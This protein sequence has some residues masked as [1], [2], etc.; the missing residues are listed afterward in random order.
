MRSFAPRYALRLATTCLAACLLPSL[1]TA[2]E[3]DDAP[4]TIKAGEAF[5]EEQDDRVEAF[6]L[7]AHGH[8][9]LQQGD[10]AGALRRFERAWR[11]DP[12]LV[13]IMERIVPIAF[14]LKHNDEATR[15][16]AIAAVQQEVPLPL[17]ERTAA[18]LAQQEQFEAACSLYEKLLNDPTPPGN[19]SVRVIHEFEIARL[20]FLLG[21][22][23]TAA[24]AFDSVRKALEQEGDDALL[25]E[26]RQQLLARPELTYTLMAESFLRDQRLDDAEAMFRAADQAKPRPG[27]LGYHLAQV[28]L[29]RGKKN[30]AEQELNKYFDA[31]L[32]SAGMAPYILLAKLIDGELPDAK[33]AADDDAVA[34]DPASPRLL[35][36]LQTLADHDPDNPLLGY[37]LADRLLRAG[38]LQR[39]ETLYKQLLDQGPSADG[40][41]G[42]VSIYSQQNKINPLLEQLGNLAFQTGSVEALDDVSQ[43]LIANEALWNKLNEAMQA[44]LAEEGPKLPKGSQM[45]M[46]LLAAEAKDAERAEQYM[47]AALAKPGIARGQFAINYAFQMFRLEEP[48]R[49]AAAFRRAIDDKLMPERAAEL[50]FYLSGA[51]T[52]DGQYDEALEAARQAA[53]LDP[54]SPRFAGRVGWVQYQAK[55]VE[56]A[57]DVYLDLMAKYDKDHTSPDTREVMRDARLILSTIA[58]EQ[59]RIGAAEEWLEQVLDEFPEDIGALNDLGYLWCDQN[60]H[61]KRSLAM[62]QKAVEA[63]P[64]NMAYRDSLGWALFKLGRFD[65]AVVELEKAANNDNP[66]GVILDHLADAYHQAGNHEKAL[67]L[68]QKAIATFDDEQDERVQQIRKKI[69]QPTSQ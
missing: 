1:A 14:T 61:L 34:S 32:T 31:K 29:A 15:Y 8:M 40:Y 65:E 21:D 63:E 3:L 4:Q 27:M 19:P 69:D 49:A 12:E 53:Q 55:R 16:A 41:R 30:E 68:W 35:E 24:T 17:L 20:S 6:S 50:Y 54:N 36:R 10:L 18:I 52:L 67:Q 42:L 66:D 62:V 58:V 33:D 47:T 2:Q 57:E 37:F 5:T 7:N 38:E 45:A 39:A 23:K 28:Q 51:L 64:E 48:T 43:K 59:K 56:E 44:G 26:I 60:K 11:F 46:A 22:F 25:D 9:L 13:P